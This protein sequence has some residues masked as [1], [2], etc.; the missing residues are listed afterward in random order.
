MLSTGLILSCALACLLCVGVSAYFAARA[1]RHARC[2]RDTRR[3]LLASASDVRQLQG[4]MADLEGQVMSVRARLGK[5]EKA[6]E[7]PQERPA[8]PVQLKSYLRK[9]AGLQ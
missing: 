3:D 2:F 4:Q 6:P 5:R 7:N 8:D 1:A 9:K